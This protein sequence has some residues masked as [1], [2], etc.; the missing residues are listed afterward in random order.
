MTDLLLFGAL[1]LPLWGYVAVTLVMTHLTVVSV[2]IFLH[3]SQAHRAVELHPLVSHPMRFWLWLT[4]GMVTREWV[5]V[6]RKHHARTETPD[7]PHSPKVEGLWRVVFGG[8]GLYRRAAGDPETVERYGRGTPDDAIERRLY[9]RHPLA[10][11]LLMLAI[12]LVLFGL[13]GALVWG[14]QVVWIPLWAAGVVNGIG[15]ALGYRNHETRDASTNIVPIGLLLGG[16]EL[17]NNHHARPGSPKLSHR[18]WE[19]DV[20][21]MYLRLLAAAGLARPK[22]LG[23]GQAREEAA[24]EDPAALSPERTSR[25][26]ARD[27][28]APWLGSEAARA[29][30]ALRRR[31]RACRERLHGAA[32]SPEQAARILETC[33]CRRGAAE[34]LLASWTRLVEVCRGLSVDPD[35]GRQA[36]E[37]WLREAR[38]SGIRQLEAFAR[39]VEGD[40]AAAS[41]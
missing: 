17:H 8:V 2:T 15:H 39:S 6:H 13:A 32:D 22:A 3:R 26:F 30:G 36:L 5:A 7:D 9:T 19:F 34:V 40:L 14:V 27:V 25:R 33:G 20:S 35:A 28:L 38:Q 41:A 12:D 29:D 4:T 21:W 18:W 11:L 16:E 10:G 37:R 24:S 23:P 1:Q 31:L